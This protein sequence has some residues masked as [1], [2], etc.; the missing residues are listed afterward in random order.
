MEPKPEPFFVPLDESGVVT[1]VL[2][3]G[4]DLTVDGADVADFV[5]V[6]L[7]VGFVFVTFATRKIH[8]GNELSLV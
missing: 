5:S 7:P 3:L 2:C 4:T 1:F 8:Q 6:T